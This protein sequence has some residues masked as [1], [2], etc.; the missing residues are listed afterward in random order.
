MPPGPLSKKETGE[1]RAAG[2]VGRWVG[3]S[4]GGRE[5]CGATSPRRV[6]YLYAVVHA[7]VAYLLFFCWFQ[8]VQCSFNGMKRCVHRRLLVVFHA[9]LSEQLRHLQ[10]EQVGLKQIFRLSQLSKFIVR[11]RAV[12]VLL[13]G[14]AGASGAGGKI[15]PRLADDVC[16]RS[17]FGA[18]G[19][20]I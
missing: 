8:P 18:F 17:P 19:H 2:S 14:W 13:T 3:R 5:R 4:V 9:D 20:I 15:Q 16:T 6:Y 7:Y 12:K 11:G 10:P 1:V